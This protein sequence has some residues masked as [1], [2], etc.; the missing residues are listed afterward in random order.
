MT[1]LLERAF[2][3]VAALP[4]EVQDEAAS[5]LLRFAGIEQPPIKLTPEEHADLA[6]AEAEAARASLRRTKKF[7]PCGRSMAGE[8][9]LHEAR[10]RAD[11]SGA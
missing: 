4:E 7:A 3:T 1:K 9:S 11:Q 5:M 6:E 10:R 2:A 8:A